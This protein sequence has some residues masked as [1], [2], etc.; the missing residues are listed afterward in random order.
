MN[1]HPNSHIGAEVTVTLGDDW[2]FRGVIEHGDGT[3]VK[4]RGPEEYPAL[5]GY[6]PLA[7]VE[8]IEEARR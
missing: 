5:S 7:D 1:A 6:Y 8:L 3:M 4:V 2:W